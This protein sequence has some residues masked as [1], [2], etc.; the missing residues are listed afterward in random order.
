MQEANTTMHYRQVITLSFLLLLGWA[1][2]VKADGLDC[3]GV[4]TGIEAEICKEAELSELAVLADVLGTVVG[5]EIRYA[6]LGF[7]EDFGLSNGVRRLLSTLTFSEIE[8]LMNSSRGLAWNF[9]FDDEHN[10]L[11]INANQDQLQDG[12]VV[13]AP[14]ANGTSTPTYVE[15][16]YV[17]DPVRTGYH[18]LGNI[19][20]VTSRTRHSRSIEKFRYQNG[21]WRLI[22]EDR[23]WA[24]LLVEFDDDLARVS[25]NHLTGQAIFDFK[26]NKGV[27]RTFT[28]QVGCLHERLSFYEI[29]YHDVDG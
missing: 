22:G 24:D 8:A 18:L 1:G 6:E 26:E 3:S 29:E 2:A 17:F 20:E 28:P 15:M 4:T 9:V 19:L 5:L 14:S 10:I 16:E 23:D 13:F 21:C 25:I 7:D 27:E 11:F 12:L